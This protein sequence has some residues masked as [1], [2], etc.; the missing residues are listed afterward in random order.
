MSA[1]NLSVRVSHWLFRHAWLEP[2]NWFKGRKARAAVFD[3]AYEYLNDVLSFWEGAPAPG[4]LRA[5]D[6]LCAVLAVER[7]ASTA[8]RSCW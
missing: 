8:K 2:R 5:K 4:E 1:F 7:G 3:A 6:L